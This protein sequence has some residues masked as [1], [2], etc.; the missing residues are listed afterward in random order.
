VS[1]NQLSDTRDN[2]FSPV[3][4]TV[5]IVAFGEV[6]RRLMDYQLTPY[7]LIPFEELMIAYVFFYGAWSLREKH[8]IESVWQ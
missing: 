5:A 7:S 8:K 3:A 1:R 2:R 4:Y 6:L